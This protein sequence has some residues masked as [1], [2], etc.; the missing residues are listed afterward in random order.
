MQLVVI[1]YLE[2]ITIIVLAIITKAQKFAATHFLWSL[3]LKF[4]H[5]IVTLL[6]S[7]MLSAW[8]EKWFIVSEVISHKHLSKTEDV[9]HVL[10][11]SWS[12]QLSDYTPLKM[13]I[14]N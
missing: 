11:N 9:F 2:D 3:R 14:F 6:N 12:S 1:I 13:T 7:N 5:Y 10:W 8:V 4:T